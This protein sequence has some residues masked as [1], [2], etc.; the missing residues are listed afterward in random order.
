MGRRAKVFWV[1]EREVLDMVK[2]SERM[3]AVLRVPLFDLP[4]GARVHSV[5]SDW[6][7]R[8]FAFIVEHPSF[9]AWADG[10]FCQDEGDALSF[11]TLDVIIQD[12]PEAT[13]SPWEALVAENRRL[14]AILATS[15]S[16][17]RHRR[18]LQAGHR[19]RRPYRQRY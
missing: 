6:Q 4:E 15:A 12:G 19:G 13:A 14:R 2:M 7:R 3:P 17:G 8:A 9:P 16:T 11:S 10:A 18:R 5:R 1:G